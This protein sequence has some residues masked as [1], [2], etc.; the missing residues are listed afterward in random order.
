MS[1]MSIILIVPYYIGWLHKQYLECSSAWRT[2]SENVD[3][4]TNHNQTQQITYYVHMLLDFVD[5]L[6]LDLQ[7][8][9]V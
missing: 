6:R 1:C 2:I 9:A 5:Y 8:C 3:P 4:Q 7:M